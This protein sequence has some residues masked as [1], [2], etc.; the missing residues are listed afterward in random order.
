MRL[1]RN[2]PQDLWS[3]SPFDQQLTSLREDINRLFEPT[4]GSQLFN[5]WSPTLDVFE[6]KDNLAV[7]VE[8]PGMRKEDID[9]SLHDG[10]LSISGE[11]KHEHENK[12]GE[13]Y[14]SERFYGRFQR[15][16]SLPK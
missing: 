6:D 12:E 14:R 1:T 2:Q 13:A 8:L 5:V 7:T 3:W 4:T 10:M 16:V 11:R 15:S 9:I